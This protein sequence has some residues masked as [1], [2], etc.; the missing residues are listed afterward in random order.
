MRPLI[1]LRQSQALSPASRA[2]SLLLVL[3]LGLTPQ[4][5]VPSRAS[6]LGGSLYAR[7]RS[8]D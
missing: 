6:R 2:Q 1:E 3:I 8:G 7:V 4:A 5:E